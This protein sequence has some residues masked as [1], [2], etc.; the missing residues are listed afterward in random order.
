MCVII[1]SM[2]MSWRSRSNENVLLLY[3]TVVADVKEKWKNLRDT[4]NGHRRN[5]AKKTVSGAGSVE[6]PTWKWWKFFSFLN[7]NSEDVE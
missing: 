5:L 2:A 4:Y 6:Q 1:I 7:Q 3:C